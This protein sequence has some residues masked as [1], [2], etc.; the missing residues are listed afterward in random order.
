MRQ[1]K[2]S[3][4]VAILIA[5]FLFSCSKDEERTEKVDETASIAF[6]AILEDLN[7]RSQSKQAAADIPACSE[8]TPAYVKIVLSRNGNSIV[9]S[10]EVPFRVDLVP[11]QMFTR[12]APELKLDQGEYS[13]DV[14]QVYD[15]SDNLIW[16]APRSGSMANFVDS[17]LPMTINLE[18]G[19]KK[20][21]DVSVLCFDDRLV[22]EYGYLFFDIH[23]NRAIEF[24]V[25]GNFCDSN[26]RHFPAA[27][28]VNLWK[29]SGD[30]NNPK[31]QIII[32]DSQNTVGVN[33]DGDNFA[34]PLCL[35]LPD[36]EG[37]DDFYVEITLLDSE[38]YDTQERIIRRGI[39]SDED[40]RALFIDEDKADYYH[41]REGSCQMEDSPALFV[42]LEM[43]LIGEGF[44]SPLGVVPSPDDSNRLFVIDQI[45]KIWIINE[46]GETL[47]QPFLDIT[48]KVIDLNHHYD[49]RGLL[50]LAFHP[51]YEIN[52]RFFVYYTAPP[53]PGGPEPGE[54]WDNLS[55]I[56]EFRVSGGN[57]LQADFSSEQVILEIK[58][59]Q[60]NHEGGTLAFGPDGYLYISIGDGGGAD[61]VGPGHVP[62]WYEV[63]AGGN[64]QDIE[65]NLLGNILRIDIDVAK[66][67]G[68]PADNPF[69]DHPGLDEIYAY[70]FRNPYR[71][72]FDMA[73]DHRL[74]VGDAGQVLW[75]EISVVEKGGN[76]GWNVMEGT[77]CFNASNHDTVLPSCPD[78][79]IYGNPLIDPVIEM[80]NHH[81]PLGGR[82]LVIVGGYVYRGNIKALQGQYIFGSFSHSHHHPA[83]EIFFS[84]PHG[85]GL[86]GF[87][88]LEIGGQDTLGYFL[89]GFGQDLQ[90]EIY[91]AVSLNMGPHGNTGRVF[92]IVQ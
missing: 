17:P 47:A 83:G 81:N 13:L 5:I 8:G 42:D 21:I 37:P 63:N 38:A 53:P 51:Q 86:W 55:R 19:V 39:I 18:A 44:V 29:F 56:S 92:K 31:G 3:R 91:V 26:G 34:E 65:S 66:P 60:S 36:S 41:F 10:T 67:Y 62:D 72:S 32:E 54:Q 45:G 80:K 40:V 11:G 52:G 69:V 48:S 71:F 35:V 78:V 82:T 25:F 87:H 16:I 6:S 33:S 15:D 79:D 14:F 50:G 57:P 64:G 75:E 1:L 12:E 7:N 74:F 76:Y 84:N 43:E 22:N 73:E 28:S 4:I 77:H 85:P 49:E 20:Y 90:G 59:P 24:C 70:G 61:D 68:I 88:E 9:G 58:Q 46:N 2:L 23:G 30:S 89:K 27:F